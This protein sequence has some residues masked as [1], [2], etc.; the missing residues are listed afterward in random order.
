M[1]EAIIMVPRRNSLRSRENTHLKRQVVAYLPGVGFWLRVTVD[2]IGKKVV[3][4]YMGVKLD[5]WKI[6]NEKRKNH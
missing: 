2:E 6:P 4:K 3:E 5:S 1:E